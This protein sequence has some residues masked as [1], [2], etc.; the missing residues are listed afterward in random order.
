MSKKHFKKI[1]G[2]VVAFETRR[3]PYDF[4]K[5]IIGALCSVVSWF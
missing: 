4:N 5:L 2:P 1:S 3:F